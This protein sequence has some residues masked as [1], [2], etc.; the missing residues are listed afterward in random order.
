M[1]L[2]EL[3]NNFV[4]KLSEANKKMVDENNRIYEA[5][6]MKPDSYYNYEE[7]F[8]IRDGALFC[9]GE[10]GVDTCD[11]YG[12]YRGG[13]PWINP[14]LEEEAQKMGYY[15]EWQKNKK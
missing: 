9:S 5:E 7:T 4:A 11:Y 3:K 13:Y 10:Y 1:N 12:E 8:F 15:W 6:G 14:I 2:E